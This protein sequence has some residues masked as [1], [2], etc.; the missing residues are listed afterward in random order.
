MP[1]FDFDNH[2]LCI[3]CRDQVCD[4]EVHCDECR[5]WPLSKRKVFVNYNHGLKARRESKKRRARLSGAA[6]S[7]DQSVYDTDTDVPLVDEPSVPVQN[8]QLRVCRFTRVPSFTRMCSFRGP[9]YGGCSIGCFIP[10]VR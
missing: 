10:F 3:K 1:A 8:V 9:L 5:G 7:S 2:T 4:L 6:H